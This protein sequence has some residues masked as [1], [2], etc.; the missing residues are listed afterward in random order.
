MRAKN[1]SLVLTLVLCLLASGIAYAQF[2]FGGPG[3]KMTVISQ[4]DVQKELKITKD[5]KKQIQE[6]LTTMSSGSMAGNPMSM[7][8]AG[9]MNAQMDAP[10]LA[11]LTPDQL[12]RLNE[13]WIQYNGPKVLTDPT[14]AGQVKLTDDQKTKI[15]AIW[16]AF[17]QVAMDGMAHARSNS[18]VNA[19]K[20]KKK[21][22]DAATLA[23]LTPDQVT[24]FTAM[25]GKHFKFMMPDEF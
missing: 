5:Q 23:L 7:P 20:Q 21:D 17:G 25:Q 11:V 12:S 22:A 4:P 13:L 24:A 18:A 9:S 1:L 2:G 19:I 10:F 14:V 3:P 6:A 16:D 8:D 15:K